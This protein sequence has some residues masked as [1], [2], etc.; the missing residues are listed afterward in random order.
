MLPS[1][2]EPWG[3]VL[4][5]MVTSGMPVLVSDQVGSLHTFL[6]NNV[7]GMSFSYLI[8]DDLKNKLL[9][10]MHLSDG[11]LL[12]MGEESVLLSKK[13]TPAKWVETLNQIYE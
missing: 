3:V 4:H 8:K 13:T 6:N 11:E 10:F 1:K 12:K 2:F 9:K 7:N 5:E